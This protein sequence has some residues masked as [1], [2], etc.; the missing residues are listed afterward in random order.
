MRAATKCQVGRGYGCARSFPRRSPPRCRHRSARA[1]SW[2]V[3]ISP[4]HVLRLPA[5]SNE[6][7]NRCPAS[8]GF[9]Q[10]LVGHT[11]SGSRLRSSSCRPDPLEELDLSRILP[12]RMSRGSRAMANPVR[13]LDA[14]SIQRRLRRCP[15]ASRATCDSPRRSTRRRARLVSSARIRLPSLSSGGAS[16]CAARN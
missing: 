14:S 13:V 9:V 12:D 7:L 2:R 11:L 4:P 16:R 1:F 5:P 3:P 6:P 10:P 8:V 15:P